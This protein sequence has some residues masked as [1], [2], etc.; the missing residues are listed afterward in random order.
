MPQGTRPARVGEEIRQ[1]ISL[2]LSREVQDPGLGFVTVTRVT[3]SP[4]LLLARIF[5]TLLGDAAARTATAKAL[6]RATPFLR[7]QLGR[8]L[9]L[10]RVPELM[11]QFDESIENQARIEKILIDL[12][13]ERAGRVEDTDA[14]E[15]TERAEG[16]GQRAEGTDRAEGTGQRAEE[17]PAP[18]SESPAATPESP[19]APIA[20]RPAPDKDHS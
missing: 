16:T 6:G 2:L 17:E 19:P 14:A 10:R 4:D 5:Y 12:A 3:V 13:E 9:R 11:F 8:R 18:S 7:R 20:E 15:G 1:E